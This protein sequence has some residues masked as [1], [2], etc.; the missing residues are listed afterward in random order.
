MDKTLAP[1]LP[2]QQLGRNWVDDVL[3]NLQLTQNRVSLSSR[4]KCSTIIAHC[5]LDLLGSRDLPTSASQIAR[6][7]AR[8]IVKRKL[9]PADMVILKYLEKTSDEGVCDVRAQ[10]ETKPKGPQE[11]GPG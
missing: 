3:S 7:T 4:L 2:T 5:S 11:T 6:T 8:M 9:T 10:L 1:H